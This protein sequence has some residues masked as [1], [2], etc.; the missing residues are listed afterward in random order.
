MPIDLLYILKCIVFNSTILWL[1]FQTKKLWRLKNPQKKKWMLSVENTLRIWPWFGFPLQLMSDTNAQWRKI[2]L[3]LLNVKSKGD[4]LSA[5]VVSVLG[6]WDGGSCF[7]NLIA[8]IMLITIKHLFTVEI[9]QFITLQ[10]SV[11]ASIYSLTENW[12]LLV[13]DFKANIWCGCW[14]FSWLFNFIQFLLYWTVWIAEM[15]YPKQCKWCFIT[16]VKLAMQYFL[17]HPRYENIFFHLY[18]S[19]AHFP[20]WSRGLRNVLEKVMTCDWNTETI[21]NFPLLFMGFL[22]GI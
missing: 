2:V 12:V 13:L 21:C 3:L 4:Y 11:P 16:C 20:I 22:E 7:C 19:Q 6:G 1:S 17:G 10:F 15:I 9:R 14:K 5:Q 8:E 18:N